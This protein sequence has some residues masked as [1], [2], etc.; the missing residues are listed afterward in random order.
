MFSKFAF[1][2]FITLFLESRKSD[3]DNWYGATSI[4]D[5]YK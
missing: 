2:H 4:N 3:A 1:T 5:I